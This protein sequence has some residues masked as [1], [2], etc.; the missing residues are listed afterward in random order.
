MAWLFI[1]ALAIW[2]WRQ[3]RRID[4]LTKQV[5]ALEARAAHAP[6]SE[7]DDVLVLDTPLPHA[8]NDEA[9]EETQAEP[10][11]ESAEVYVLTQTAPPLHEEDGALLLTERVADDPPAP[12][13]ARRF[14]QWLA[15]NGLAWLGGGAFALG[16]VMLVAIAAQQSWFT[17]LVRLYCALGLGVGLIGASEWLRRRPGAHALVAALLAGAGAATF[18]ATAWGAHALYDYIDAP[19]AGAALALC[20][21]I[22]LAL[23]FRHGQALGVLALLAALLAPA[24]AH[25]GDW[26]AQALTFYLGAAAAAGFGVAALRRWPWVGAV[27]LLGLYFWFAAAIGEGNV[28][29]A[30]AL[31]SFAS[32]GGVALAFRKPIAETEARYL[33]WARAHAIAPAI[34]IA[35]SSIA[36]I[37]TWLAMA[38]APNGVVSGPAWVGAMFVALAAVS[39][40][41]RVAP[42]I[43]LAV[44]I[45]ALVAGFMAYLVAR[46]HPLEPQFYP[47]ILFAAAMIAAS[48]IGA[49]P[50]RRER[51]LAAIAGG[52]GAALLTALGASISADWHSPSAY[53]PLLIGGAGLLGAAWLQARNVAKPHANLAVDAWA[54]AGAALLA[55]ALESIFAAEWR[56]A[57][58]AGLALGLGAAFAQRGWRGLGWS[59]IGAATLALAHAF[60]GQTAGAALSLA[61][62]IW[63]TLGVLALGA[64]FLFAG[65][66][67][68]AR[69]AAPSPTGE[70]LSAAAIVLALLAAFF[71]LRWIAAGGAG[72]PLDRFT[73]TALRGLALLAAAHIASPR[74]GQ[75][76]GR[77]SA[78]RGHALMAAGFGLIAFT[79]GVQLNPWWG[80]PPASIPGPPLFNTLA[81][82]FAAPAAL[83]LLAARRLYGTQLLAARLYAG[84]G[85]LLALLWALL[86]IRHAFHA[87]SMN[88]AY[89]G[90]VEGA[91]Y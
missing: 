75:A 2:V 45:G 58:H 88:A 32:L 71:A 85:A 59:A 51:A 81:L 56:V 33:S 52:A 68:C 70:A 10:Q 91:C 41:A 37:W 8:S 80:A 46:Y 83:L 86:E 19:T 48:A 28:R 31:A 35:L 29:R 53:A 5:Q 43:V 24:I 50:H 23:A 30:L 90:A 84:A 6:A 39:V 3:G 27:T 77:L 79:N 49:R 55:I 74:A 54:C 63:Q 78:L 42:A 13:R 38:E 72:A 82:S 89:V 20:A 62:P 69:R 9:E 15:E 36:L 12:P 17:P 25:A 16:G 76:F 40:R 14:E 26:P 1:L 73:E 57:A 18:Y 7:A 65:A 60:L 21:L 64:I 4:A 66:H 11:A 61:A 67:L 34:A 47:F 22:L 87:A 44:A